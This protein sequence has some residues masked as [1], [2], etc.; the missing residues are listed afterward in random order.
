M[1]HFK[2]LFRRVFVTKKLQHNFFFYMKFAP[3]VSCK[4]T[5]VRPGLI[6]LKD[7]P[8]GPSSP[9]ATEDD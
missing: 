2:N 4:D 8:L 1:D 7:P 5:K 3:F 9:G 6:P